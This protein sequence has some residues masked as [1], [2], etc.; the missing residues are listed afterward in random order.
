[1]TRWNS[2]D[3]A[4]EKQ[5]SLWPMM[6]LSMAAL[7]WVTNNPIVASTIP[8][9]LAA[10]PQLRA[11]FWLLHRDPNGNRRRVC[12]MFYVAAAF[13]QAAGIAFASFLLLML[14][15][16]LLGIPPN[17]QRGEAFIVI[18]LVGVLTTSL[19]GVIAAVFAW[20]CKIRV[21]VHPRI[22]AWCREDFELLKQVRFAIAKFN[23][24]T[25]VLAAGLQLPVLLV[26]TMVMILATAKPD[27]FNAAESSLSLAIMTVFYILLP[28]AMLCLQFWISGRI[29]ASQPADCWT[30]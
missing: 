23:Y 18:I 21:W 29:V 2:Q 10:L 24:A 20:L 7:Y 22:Q 12:F 30:D 11:A 1:M 6:A 26:G 13:W 15:G 5:S 14:F 9:L 8:S 4:R 19:L 25:F 27:R 28:I 3:D 16:N 17:A